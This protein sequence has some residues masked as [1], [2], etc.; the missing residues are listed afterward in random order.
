MTSRGQC[1]R[2]VGGACECPGGG[3][4]QFF[5]G[6]M[7]SRRQCPGCVCSGVA[8]GGGAGGAIAPP[9]LALENGKFGNFAI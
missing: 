3:V 9:P 2:G 1:P 4:C 7:T 5:G 8:T 6:W